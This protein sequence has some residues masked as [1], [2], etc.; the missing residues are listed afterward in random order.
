[1]FGLPVHPSLVHFP[2]ALFVSGALAALFF[3]WRQQPQGESWGIYG[4]LAGWILTLPALI[5]GLIDKNGIPA[6]APAA[7]VA[8]L[9]TTLMIATWVVFGGAL[10]F[11]Y[12]RK[13]QDRL[14]GSAVWLWSA[15]L[16]LGLVLLTLAGHQGARLVYEFGVGVAP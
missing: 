5:S 13:K 9:H 14:S 4:L 12:L 2:I 3:R 15:L 16:V 7:A 6:D 10:Y 8:D 1:M 11:Y